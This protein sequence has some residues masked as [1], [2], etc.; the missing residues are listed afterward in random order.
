MVDVMVQARRG[1]EDMSHQET[2]LDMTM[3]YAV[4]DALRRELVQ[5]SRTAARLDD[6]PRRL[7]NSALGWELFKKF[8][9]VHHTAEDVSVWPAVRAASQRH[10]DRLALVEAMEAE[11]A[12]IDPL[13][14]AV[15]E[16]VLDRDSGHL[17][18]GDLVD[19]LVVEL[20]A[21][22]A[23]EERDGL[24]LIDVSLTPEQWKRFSDDHRER[25]GDDAP[26]YLP[27]LLDQAD[28]GQVAAILSKL[29][30]KLVNA[31]LDAWGP[32]YDLLDLWGSRDG[33]A[34]S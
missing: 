4:H 9:N 26:R 17:R 20:G 14:A 19:A 31:Y 3:M 23:H 8:L 5:V 27:W 29:P 12:R 22:L 16:A 21:H 2:K 18:L 7:L 24:E 6:D 10:P 15:D 33:V 11:H 25:V 30:D 34:A 13:V 28:H 32:A 1:G